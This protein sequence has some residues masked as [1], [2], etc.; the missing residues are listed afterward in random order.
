MRKCIYCKTEVN[1]ESLMDFCE[2]CGKK[3]FGEKMFYTISQNMKEANKRGDLNQ[4]S[5]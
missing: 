3:A 2:P 1:S 4:S 5:F